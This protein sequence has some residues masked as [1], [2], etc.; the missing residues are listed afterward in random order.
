MRSQPFKGIWAMTEQPDGA[1]PEFD[2]ADR[3]RKALRHGR[4]TVSQ[5][6]DYL[7]VS[8]QSVGNWINARV[9]PGHQTLLLWAM[10]CG[11]DYD[12][13]AGDHR[14]PVR[15]ARREHAAAGFNKLGNKAPF[16]QVRGLYGVAA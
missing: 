5:M 14:R 10:R 8:R 12:W 16:A 13:L 1:V 6:A 7:G 15:Y 3:M 11:V 2:L 9:E 4:V